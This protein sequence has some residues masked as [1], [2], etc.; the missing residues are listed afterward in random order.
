MTARRKCTAAKLGVD[1]CRSETRKASTG[2]QSSDEIVT[3]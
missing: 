2:V 3:K 1:C